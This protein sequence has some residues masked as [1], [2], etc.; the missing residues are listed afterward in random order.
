[1]PNPNGY[2]EFVKAG[3][4]VLGNVGDFPTLDHDSLAALV[5]TNAEPL[6]LLRLGLTR[7]CVMPM[8]SALTNAAGGMNQL[9]RMKRLVQL[10]AAEG[11]LR[12]MENRP[13]EA[14]R[15]YVEAL[16]FGNEMS[17][18]GFIIT[19]LVGIACEAIG[20][21]PL[22]KLVPKLNPDEARAVLRDLDKLDTGHVTWAEVKQSERRFMRYQIRQ[23]LNPITWVMGWWQ[24]RRAVQR[25]ELKH[26]TVVA[27]EHLIV[28]ELALRGYQSEQG[29]PPARLDDLAIHYLS[30]VPVDPFS[31]QPLVYRAQGTNW[32][33]SW[34]QRRFVFRLAVRTG[35]ANPPAHKTRFV[36]SLRR[37]V[38]FHELPGFGSSQKTAY[39][40][41]V[42]RRTTASRR[43][44]R[45]L[46]WR[47]GPLPDLLACPADKSK[48]S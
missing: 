45:P 36:V 22:A 38:L 12:E 43:S 26:K 46:R 10:L 25:A 27:H 3:E 15:S 7:Q 35:Q 13:A 30:H 34:E 29:H 31:G 18:G 11:R 44:A 24:S 6:R 47:T 17:R 39:A 4:A 16:R 48:V 20:Y 21:A 32:P 42:R 23:H 40:A 8:D 5:S 2:D 9:A 33:G 41:A 37:L 19:R 14:A 1:L 28:A